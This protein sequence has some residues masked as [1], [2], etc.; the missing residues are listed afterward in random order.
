MLLDTK[1]PWVSKATMP[2]SFDQSYV[3]LRQITFYLKKIEVK[4]L[5]AKPN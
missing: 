3:T 1:A 2:H 4:T 5:Y